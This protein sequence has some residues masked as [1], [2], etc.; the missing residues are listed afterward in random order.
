MFDGIV[1]ALPQL[2]VGGLLL[3]AFLFLVYR[4]N[5]YV[6]LRNEAKRDEAEAGAVL[7]GGLAKRVT[8]LETRLDA[9]ETEIEK[10]HRERD[11]AR[12]EVMGL[13]AIMEGWG[14]IDQEVQRRLSSDREAQDAEKRGKKGGDDAGNR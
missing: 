3:L 10:C 7:T 9:A 2:G 1:Q 14:M 6:G 8:S 5:L 13:K 11:E 4:G 12:G